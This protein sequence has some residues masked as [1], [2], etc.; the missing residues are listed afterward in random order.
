MPRVNHDAA[1]Y[2]AEALP[3]G[4][5]EMSRTMRSQASTTQASAVAQPSAPLI[6]LI[7][8]AAHWMKKRGRRA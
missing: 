7:A 2:G 4:F 5:A 1:S 6:G 8:L 3:A